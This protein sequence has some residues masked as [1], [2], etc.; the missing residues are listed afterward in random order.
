MLAPREAQ[1]APP[2]GVVSVSPVMTRMLSS[3]MPSAE[4]ATC[5]MIV[6]VPCPCSVTLT[7]QRTAPDGSTLSTQPSCAVMRAPPTP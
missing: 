1:V 6:S 2:D 4:A 5:A 3:G 7:W